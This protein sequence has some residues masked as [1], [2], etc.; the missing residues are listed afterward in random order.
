[1]YH[2]TG[3]EKHYRRGGDVV[4]VLDGVDLY[5]PDGT[6]LAVRGRPGAGTSTLLRIL[7]GLERPTRGRVLLDGT[8]LATLTASRLGRLR[9]DAIGLLGGA[10]GGATGPAAGATARQ[11]V[12]AALVPLG[13]RPA[14]RRELAGAAL[15]EVGLAWAGEVP[16]GRLP[17]SA[18]RRAA[19]ARA[20][21]TRPTVLLADRPTA[22]LPPDGRAEFA[23]L[24][25]RVCG[26]RRLTCVLATGDEELLRCAGRR[27][28]LA[29]G[30]LTA[31]W[32]AAGAGPVAGNGRAGAAAWCGR[33]A[34]R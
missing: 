11:W 25:A 27:V 34:G 13:L 14:D 15:A 18:R 1:M 8:D 32:P 17:A 28:V 16:P 30:R 19:L 33:G 2:L 3:V 20:L 12:A 23:A 24:L 22:G 26:E 21:V 4:R 10:D 31:E 29:G 5:V 7:G 6:V 9:G